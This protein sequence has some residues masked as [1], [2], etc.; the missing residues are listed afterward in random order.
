MDFGTG[1]FVEGSAERRV[2]VVKLGLAPGEYT[3]R[4]QT[5]TE[6]GRLSR[7]ASA[8]LTVKP[9]TPSIS[10]RRDSID[11]GQVARLCLNVYSPRPIAKWTIDWGD[12][13]SSTFD[14]T[15]FSLIAAKRYASKSVAA[16]YSITLKL[17]DVA[18]YGAKTTFSLGVQRV[19]AAVVSAPAPYFV[20]PKKSALNRSLLDAYF[21]S[22][23]DSERD[24]E[25]E[26]LVE[27]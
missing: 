5:Q 7:I 18:G 15:S 17:V 22:Y 19:E 2:D 1:V 23:A 11:G 9:A 8:S 21:A 26:I 4:L 13:T 24:F 12:G 3:L 10:V 16:D 25:D 14:S 27:Y 20:A 6:D